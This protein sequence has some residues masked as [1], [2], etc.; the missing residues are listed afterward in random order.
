MEKQMLEDIK[1][2]FQAFLRRQR[3]GICGDIRA[4]DTKI[5]SLDIKIGSNFELLASKIN[6]VDTK[7][8][9]YRRDDLLAEIHAT[10]HKIDKVEQTLSTDFPAIRTESGSEGCKASR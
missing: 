3:E 6:A 10:D 2:F 7:I 1:E 5:E 9:S 4:L 8:E